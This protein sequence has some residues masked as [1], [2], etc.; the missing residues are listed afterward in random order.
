MAAEPV[1]L[2]RSTSGCSTSAAPASPPSPCTT[3]R[4]PGGTPASSASCAKNDA[5]AGVCSEGFTTAAFPQKIAG[6][7]FHATFG[8]GVLKLMISAATPSGCRIVMT[9]RCGMLA[10]VVRPYERRP[11]P[12]TK[13][14]ISIAASVSPSCERLRL[15]GLLDDDRGGLVAALAEEEGE[16][17]DDVSTRDSGALGPRGLRCPRRRDRVR[18]VVGSRTCDA[19]EHR[20]VGGTDLLEPGAGACRQGLPVDEVLDVRQGYQADQPPSTTTFEPVA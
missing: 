15:A 14:P 5:E 11:S 8:S 19:A 18:N 10:V 6:N 3:L 1:K 16:L 13:S 2:T 17:P 12:A 20:L 9:V 4:T 7:A